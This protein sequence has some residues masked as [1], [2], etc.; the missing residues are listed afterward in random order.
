MKENKKAINI[1]YNEN[2]LETMRNW[3]DNYVDYIITSPPYNI[4]SATYKTKGKKGSKK[5]ET[6][7]DDKSIGDYLNWQNNLI[8]E[9]LR[10]TKNHIFYNIQLVS[11]NKRAVLALIGSFQNKIKDIYIWNKN[12][13]TPNIQKGIP[14]SKYEFII[15]FSKKSPDLRNFED[16]K[17][18]NYF[19]TVLDIDVEKNKY[20]DKHSAIFP[21][22]LPRTIMRN[23]GEDGD[24]WYDP[25]GGT[26]TTAVAAI[27]ENK[28][29]ILSEIDKGYIDIIN[30]RIEETIKIES[31]LI[32]NKKEINQ[33]KILTLDLFQN[34][35]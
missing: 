33:G 6:Y 21:E 11:G 15:I 17:F 8:N 19:S 31:Q 22:A 9:M 20:S 29:F 2:C 1:V 30:K 27:K 4:G 3:E 14:R 7:K 12:I 5:Y 16:A 34:E 26:G 25:F 24:I 18:D 32:F 13:A 10:V 28:S 35:K 23:F